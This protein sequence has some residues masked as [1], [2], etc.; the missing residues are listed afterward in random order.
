MNDILLTNS[1]RY[2]C[3]QNARFFSD[4]HNM[5]GAAT[6]RFAPENQIRTIYYR[7]YKNF[8]ESDLRRDLEYVPF[9]VMDLF[10]D[11]DEMAWYT[12]SLIKYVVDHH[13]PVKSKT[14]PSQSM[15]YINSVLRKTQYLRN[16]ARNNFKKY[17]KSCWEENKRLRNV[18]VEIRKYSM[19]KYFDE[20]CSQQD[21][22]FWKT[23]SPFSLTRNSKME[24]T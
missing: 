2:I 9:H 12:S 17:G 24:I 7:S 20:R 8:I 15:P 16:M 23:I 21:K 22:N 6:K 18:V 14:V 13:A 3:T 11:I 1:R 5:I 4:F 19:G 10:D